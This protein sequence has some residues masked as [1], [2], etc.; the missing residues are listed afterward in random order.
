[1]GNIL[2]RGSALRKEGDPKGIPG[3]G[4][5][6]PT[7]GDSGNAGR[8]GA[9]SCPACQPAE[10]PDA[11]LAKLVEYITEKSTTRCWISSVKTQ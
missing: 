1:M 8:R 10:V 11:T 3:E 2:T 4:V 7:I 9:C 5:S 6:G